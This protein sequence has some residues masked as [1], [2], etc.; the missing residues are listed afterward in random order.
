MIEYAAVS[1]WNDC[2]LCTLIRR[3]YFM[4]ALYMGT[5]NRR[6]SVVVRASVDVGSPPLSSHK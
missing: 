2:I 1:Q 6:G 3:S 5:A 4:N